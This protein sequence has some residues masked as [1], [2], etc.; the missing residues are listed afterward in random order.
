MT[1]RTIQAAIDAAAQ[2][3][4]VYLPRGTHRIRRTIT[5][6]PGV[7]LDGSAGARLVWAGR[8][9]GGP[10]LRIGHGIAEIRN[11]VFADGPACCAAIEARFPR[12]AKRGE[13]YDL[14]HWKIVRDSKGSRA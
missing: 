14:C 5:V 8:K 1:A 10:I 3:R 12:P 7:A 9:G 2:P 11:I 6:L 13:G 4:T